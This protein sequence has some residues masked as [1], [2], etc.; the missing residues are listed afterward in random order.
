MKAGAGALLAGWRPA[1]ATAGQR[2]L[3]VC[4]TGIGPA[5]PGA[6]FEKVAELFVSRAIPVCCALDLSAGAHA[7]VFG[8]A[9][10]L[11][12]REPGLFE[13]MIQVG[14]VVEAGRYFQMRQAGDLR[15]RVRE[16]LAASGSTALSL[17]VVSLFAAGQREDLDLA[18]FRSAGFLGLVAVD[19]RKPGTEI[20]LV[21]V[22]QISLSGGTELDPGDDRD[23]ALPGLDAMLAASGD[24]LVALRVPQSE[25]TGGEAIAPGYAEVAARLRAELDR[26]TLSGTRP[27]DLVQQLSEQPPASIAIL[28]APPGGED[29]GSPIRAMMRELDRIGVGYTVI[30]PA[31]GQGA[32]PDFPEGCAMLGGAQSAGQGAHEFLADCALAR[33]P[34]ALEAEDPFR[35]V[36]ADGAAAGW[37]E[38]G[39][40]ARLLIPAAR[41]R[42]EWA[43]EAGYAPPASDRLIL[44]TAEDVATQV[45]R[46]ALAQSL[47]SLRESGA[48]KLFSVARFADHVLAPDPILD[49]LQSARRRRHFDPPQDGALS[50]EERA[51][52]AEDARLAW[53]YIDRLTSPTTGLCAGAVQQNVAGGLIAGPQATLWD[54]ASQIQGIIAARALAIIDATEAVARIATLLDNL[55]QQEIDGLR[56]PPL[57]V[58]TARRGVVSRGFDFCDTGRFLIA[59]SSAV[60]AGLLAD[61]QAASVFDGWD[62]AAS[63]RDGRPFDHDR[64]GWSESYFNHCT[65]FLSRGLA[66]WGLEVASPYPAPEPE[67]SADY[68]MRLLYSVAYIGPYGT[69]PPLLE[70][71]ELGPT[72]ATRCLAEVLFDAQISSFEQTGLPK[73]VSE[74]SLNRSPWFSYQGFR[75]DAP[76]D[77]GWVIKSPNPD[78]D[79]ATDTWRAG[80]EAVSSKA[81]YL[82]AAHYPHPYSHSLKELVRDKARIADLGFSVGIFTQTGEAMPGYSDINTNGVILSAI[83]HMVRGQP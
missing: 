58:S 37:S 20:T 38:M 36:V 81:A 78:P 44:I 45:D 19:A 52:L 2:N 13:V 79:Y 55:P 5:T 33:D 34:S 67:D 31:P 23:G 50:A 4:L 43:L 41:G 74:T 3:V 46:I 32:V 48:A 61:D 42:A 12:R 15:H 40:D 72:A 77:E 63:L 66:D 80:V 24:V 69:E 6:G 83:A 26:G 7:P 10:E 30:D 51:A 17:P 25:R 16:L 14:P 11:A 54:L 76:E 70:A 29:P 53:R 71:N 64:R 21:G 73:C 56:L 75:V 8:T 28:L 68:R 35:I 47:E 22:E 1:F 59:L 49:R 57:F 9:A 82:W 18:A 62:I 65:P 60:K 27:V 39:P